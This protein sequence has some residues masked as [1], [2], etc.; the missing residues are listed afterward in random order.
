VRDQDLV[1]K[2]P[3]GRALLGLAGPVI[4]GE[5]LHTAFHIVDLFWVRALGP[6]AT[7]AI[8]TS[9][10]TLWIA[11]SL[12]NL[13]I[14]GLGAHV[15]R[16]IGAGDRERAGH[17]VAQAFWLCIF[18][19]IPVMTLGAA[20]AGALYRLVGTDPQVSA[21]GTSY[22]RIIALGMPFTFLYLTAGA[23]MRACGNTRTPMKITSACVVVNAAIAPLLVYG[24]GPVPALGVAGSAV[25]TVASIGLA[26]V[27]YVV[28][29]RRGHP[30][31]PV[32]AASLV[33]PDRDMLLSLVRVGA[34]YCAVGTLFSAV[35]LWY[36]H[37]ASAFGEASLAI[38]GIGN[39]LESITYL[40]ADGFA[41]A[42]STFVGQ[43][44]GAGDPSRAERGAW[45]AARI[46][47]AIGAG[48][49]LIFLLAPEPLLMI[50]TTDAGALRIGVPYMRILALCQVFTG[51]EGA[52]GGG[53]AGAGNTVPPMIVHVAFAV[54]RVPLAWWAVSGLGL[55]IFGITWTMTLTCIVRASVLAWWFRRGNWKTQ[56]LP[57][58]RRP[59]PPA[60]E[61][62]PTGV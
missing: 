14:T 26:V 48:L 33:R 17:V 34:P 27:I 55:G 8:T 53:F 23:V 2:G 11:F 22:L 25:A 10:F 18:L 60:E 12:A 1:L 40:T 37:L 9:M 47:S 31:L 50:F 45:H 28:L 58:A 15:S 19:S 54:A 44:L 59:L 21:A 39:R 46:M 20:G 51:M 7:A 61:P 32:R 16:A 57:G 42:S 62:E 52:I 43:N 29:V 35:Y 4:A 24:V 38:L 5:A 30:D 13:V 41:I 49:G 56:E 6:W 3:I 36:A